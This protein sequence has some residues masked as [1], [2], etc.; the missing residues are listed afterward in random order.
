M[1]MNTDGGSIVAVLWVKN[2]GVSNTGWMAV[3]LMTDE[4]TLTAGVGLLLFDMAYISAADTAGRASA[5]DAT[6]IAIGMVRSLS[7]GMATVRKDGEVTGLAGLVP[8]ATYYL[9]VAEG[10]ITNV[11]PSASGQIVQK[12]GVAVD[13]TTILLQVDRDFTVL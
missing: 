2:T 10:G 13:A 4:Q 3:G 1:Y 7:G 8:G 6:K 12:I 11:P 9:D 5:A